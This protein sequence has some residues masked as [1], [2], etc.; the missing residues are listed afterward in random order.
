VPAANILCRMLIKTRHAAADVDGAHPVSPGGGIPTLSSRSRG[1]GN[2]VA[3]IHQHRPQYDRRRHR[4]GWTGITNV[5]ATRHNLNNGNGIRYYYS[6]WN[7]ASYSI[8]QLYER[9]KWLTR[10]GTSEVLHGLDGELFRGITHQFNYDN[11]A[12]GP[13]VED[14]VLTWGTGA[15]AGTGVLLALKDDGATGTMWIQLLT[16]VPPVEDL[17]ID[18]A[19]TQTF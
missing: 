15:T 12:S 7:R 2:A 4:G 9:A 1:L 3:A 8:N 18:G 17:Q 5:E 19:P 10:R 13:F 16:G 11:E 14:T 6:Q